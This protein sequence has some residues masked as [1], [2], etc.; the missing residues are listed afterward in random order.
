MSI[1]PFYFPSS[2][3][4]NNDNNSPTLRLDSLV[5]TLHLA[6]S[7][8]DWLIRISGTTAYCSILTAPSSLM[9]RCTVACSEITSSKCVLNMFLNSQ[10]AH[11][12]ISLVRYV[13]NKPKIKSSCQNWFYCYFGLFRGH[14][15]QKYWGSIF[16]APQPHF[17]T[18][19]SKWPPLGWIFHIITIV[20]Y[21]KS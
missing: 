18:P 15:S 21:I 10:T 7:L 1:L 17:M 12:V 13:R 9:Y 11:V 6:S 2:S 5:V 14:I 4:N 20:S 16:S 19:F 8:N 3:S